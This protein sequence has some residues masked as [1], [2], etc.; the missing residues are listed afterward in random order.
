MIRDLLISDLVELEK[1]ADFPLVNLR[2][3]PK[4]LEKTVEDSKGLLG[5]VI[6]TNTAEV[7]IILTD[8]SI[9]DRVKA[10]KIIEDL[11]YRELIPKGFRDI[12]TFI[13]DPKYAQILVDHFKFEYAVGKALVRRA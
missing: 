9:R 12:H 11:V 4:L 5:S 10:L 3:Q 2:T 7:S 8:R 13:T 1:F 6:V